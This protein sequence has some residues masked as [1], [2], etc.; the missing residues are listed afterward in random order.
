MY[1]VLNSY[2]D[3]SNNLFYAVKNF[4]TGTDIEVVTEEELKLLVDMNLEIKDVNDNI[5]TLTNDTLNLQVEDITEKLNNSMNEDEYD[6]Y[7]DFYSSYED[8]DSDIEETS[9]EENLD[10]EDD[11]FDDIFN[12][13]EEEENNN[14]EEEVDLDDFFSAYEDD[15]DDV[16]GSVV[17]KLYS[18]LTD[19]QVQIL[20]RYYLWYS[21]RLFN[22]AQKD[23]TFGMSNKN[24]LKAKKVALK[25]LKGN[26]EWRYAGFLDTGSKKRG[27]TCTLGHPLRYMHLA[28][29]ITVG[30]IETCFFGE[31]FNL[32]Y[33]DIIKSNSCIV[34]GIK[35]IGDFFE[36]DSECI[37]NLQ[38]AQRESLRDMATIYEY[39]VNNTVDEANATFK[40]L[41]E[42]MACISK[43]DTKNRL[44]KKDY[45]PIVPHSASV[46][47]KQF[48][49]SNLIPP[50]SLIQTIRSCLVGW[51][52]GTKY[53]SNKWTGELHYPN[54][55]FYTDTLPV[56]LRGSKEDKDLASDISS[57][58]LKCGFARL[59]SDFISNYLYV[60]YTYELC[61]IYK[62]DADINKDEGG[63]S[64]P[65]KARLNMHYCY[66][67]QYVFE[68]LDF[69]IRTTV[70]LLKLN[71]KIKSFVNSYSTTEYP[72][73]IVLSN[74]YDTPKQFYMCVL[75]DNCLVEVINEFD[76]SGGSNLYGIL[77]FLTSINRELR[78][79]SR[80]RYRE[81]KS[82]FYSTKDNKFNLEELYSVVEA[83]YSEFLDLYNKF[84]SFV[85][86]RNTKFINEYNAKKEKKEMERKALEEAR[87]KEEDEQLKAHK[88]AEEQ[89]RNNL[90]DNEID[91]TAKLVEYLI[92]NVDNANL[93][94]SWDLP[95][96]IIETVKKSGKEPS[97]RQLYHLKRLYKQISGVDYK[98][99]NPSDKLSLD[100]RPD[101][102]EAI[103]YILANDNLISD[104][105]SRLKGTSSDETKFKGVL[106][107]ILKYGKISKKQLVYAN[108]SKE[109][110]DEVK[111][112]A[113]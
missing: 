33:E 12:Y 61:G 68:D 69:S 19:E 62:Y 38:K 6:E 107:S 72:V 5:V 52:D 65:V 78:Q 76:K 37:R 90:D 15:E 48:R 35:C 7:D 73:D 113:N 96:K 32:N 84:L 104:C 57:T 40:F 95:K 97:D 46:F 79:C 92:N 89:V 59:F 63:R 23:P 18:Y 26:S 20:G 105:I 103:D 4:A 71:N 10:D 85:E 25:Q 42:V 44:L 34:F 13:S 49:D 56:L 31:D 91:T 66:D 99:V 101:L 70:L 50:K 75:A 45:V 14:D 83:K 94:S 58:S 11:D 86:E 1:T 16:E 88:Q 108:A 30:D 21:Q 110:F 106:N 9:E 17:S 74:N 41:D 53:F 81:F 54:T 51:T 64:K 60:A 109:V 102:K 67:T 82:A 3:D 27:Y 93:D 55:K 36:V 2:R 28:W 29:D 47:Y 8:D 24:K 80:K 77:E 111:G 98:G 39:Y 100:S 112:G 22:D 43:W 87:K